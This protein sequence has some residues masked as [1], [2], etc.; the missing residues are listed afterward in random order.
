MYVMRLKG[1][2]KPF[3]ASWIIHRRFSDFVSLR[4]S[5]KAEKHKNLPALP[6]RRL[7]GST[8]SVVVEERKRYFA[9]HVRINQGQK[10]QR[11]KIVSQICEHRCN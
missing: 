8:T 9:F 2:E 7:A 6:R 4:K 10:H 5:L 11:V 1:L 3:E